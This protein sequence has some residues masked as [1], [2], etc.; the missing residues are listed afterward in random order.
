MKPYPMALLLVTAC[1]APGTVV[2][3]IGDAGALVGE[4][5]GSYSSDETGRSGSIVFT[6]AAGTDSAFGDVVMVP[7]TE[8]LAPAGRAGMEN[9]HLH[10]LPRV[11]TISFVQCGDGEV[12]GRL[13]V[14]QDPD[15]HER[16]S[17]N[18][19]GHLEGNTL[20]GSF[21]SLFETSGHRA[22][23]KW[24]VSRKTSTVPPT[25]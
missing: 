4:W 19:T 18:F 8:D 20:K 2:P 23:G 16:V 11:L 9:P 21:V 14:Y 15:T 1:T 3:V 13:D 12:T 25:A 7:A 17:T 5:R 10:R 22:G 6:L 24:E